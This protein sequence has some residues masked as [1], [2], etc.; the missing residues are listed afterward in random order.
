VKRHRSH[1]SG[2]IRLSPARADCIAVVIPAN[3]AMP[4]AKE[5]TAR[6]P[7]SGWL[8]AQIGWTILLTSTTSLHW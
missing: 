2:T 3:S 4:S 7:S 6:Q 8:A 5:M 1:G